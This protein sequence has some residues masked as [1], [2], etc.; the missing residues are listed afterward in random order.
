MKVRIP[1][2]MMEPYMAGRPPVPPAPPE[3]AKPMA[4]SG[5]TAVKVTPWMRGRRT[6]ILGPRPA[7]W[8]MVAMPQVSRSALMRWTVVAASRFRP[9]EMTR[10]T[11]TA[12]A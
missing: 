4:M 1:A 2:A 8:M 5:D 10:G 9:W 12:P 11:M 7:D 3:A 6:P